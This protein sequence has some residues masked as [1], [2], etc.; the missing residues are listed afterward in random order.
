MTMK[1]SWKCFG[2]LM[3]FFKKV[4][5]LACWRKKYRFVKDF[6][7]IHYILD[8]IENRVSFNDVELKDGR[9]IGF[10]I[11]FQ[12]VI[13]SR[14]GKPS[15][16][17]IKNWKVDRIWDM[18]RDRF[19]SEKEI[20]SEVF[21]SVF[22]KFHPEILKHLNARLKARNKWSNFLRKEIR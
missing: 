9:K 16:C 13:K 5:R 17:K 3:N 11:V 1:N 12:H 20:P 2:G 15:G 8:S 7:K 22:L 4:C 6:S 21:K 10:G 18:D 14:W 19:L